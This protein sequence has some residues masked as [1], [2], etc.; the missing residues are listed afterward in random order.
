MSHIRAFFWKLIVLNTVK[1]HSWV[2]L[3][4]CFLL[5]IMSH[6]T[7]LN[8]SNEVRR[9]PWS[10]YNIPNR[11]SPLQVCAPGKIVR[12]LHYWVVLC[13]NKTS[14]LSHSFQ[15]STKTIGWHA[16]FG[17]HPTKLAGIGA[18]SH[19]VPVDFLWW[20]E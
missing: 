1:I 11:A 12:L 15:E 13:T 9:L 6:G 16:R 10:C 14:W 8:F 20:Q 19:L 3:W 4:H 7:F 17:S 18:L 2:L 5:K